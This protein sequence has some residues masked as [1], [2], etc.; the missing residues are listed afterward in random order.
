MELEQKAE[1]A[2]SVT[3]IS[4]VILYNDD[5]HTFDEVIAQVMKAISCSLAKAESITNEVHNKGRAIVFS[6]S[7]AVCIKVSSI[8]E[9]IHL[10]TDIEI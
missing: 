5:W 6:G 9:E 3:T 7:I 2:D 8:L 4:K 1:V 10:L